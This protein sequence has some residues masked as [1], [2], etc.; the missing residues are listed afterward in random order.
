MCLGIVGNLKYLSPKVLLEFIDTGRIDDVND[1]EAFV[2]NVNEKGK[3]RYTR[4]VRSDKGGQT[5]KY[6]DFLESNGPAGCKV[7]LIGNMEQFIIDY[8]KGLF[9]TN[10]TLEDLVTEAEKH[11]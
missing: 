10:F 5:Y 7:V 9:V 3:Y 8:N 1:F 11:I 2:Q 4:K 6:V